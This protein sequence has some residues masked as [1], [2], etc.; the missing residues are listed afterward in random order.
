MDQMAMTLSPTSP[1]PLYHQIA[2][3][4]RQTIEAGKLTKGDFLPSEIELAERWRVSRP[5]ARRAIQQLVDQGMLVRKRGVG[6]QV[7]ASHVRRGIKLSSLYDDLASSGRSPTTSVITLEQIASDEETARLLEIPVATPVVY[8]E[9]IRY[10]DGQPLAIMH[11]WLTT[12]VGETLSA[13]ALERDGLYSLLRTAGVRPREAQQLI[14]A[15]A[16]GAE[17]A[18][19]LGLEPGAPLLIVQRV[20]QDDLGRKVELARHAYDARQYTIEMTLVEGD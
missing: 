14:E 16:A 20:L 15:R 6:T 7:V 8:L 9:R 13:D 3:Q 4:L 11:N 5:T 2:D 17:D 12:A 10:A 18:T 1:V 19:T